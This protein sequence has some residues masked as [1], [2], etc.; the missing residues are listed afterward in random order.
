MLQNM[1]TF[2][3]IFLSPDHV[4]ISEKENK[5]FSDQVSEYSKKFIIQRKTILK[6]A[7]ILLSIVV[8]TELIG[9][10]NEY[11]NYNNDDEF[12]L[13]KWSINNFMGIEISFL[14][15][16]VIKIVLFSFSLHFWNTYKKSIKFIHVLGLIVIYLQ[17]AYLF[18]LYA[19]LISFNNTSHNRLNILT[20]GKILITFI[21]SIVS[22]FL[23][24]A[25]IL[26]STI[27]RLSVLSLQFKIKT[28]L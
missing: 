22:Y 21:I 25:L 9:L 3:R 7:I 17:L 19:K 11:N 16:D 26:Q 10:I 8:I 23:P 24:I 13:T 14:I 2:K 4:V 15:I 5:L 20:I 28:S 27:S 1:Q 12:I 6:L 18:I